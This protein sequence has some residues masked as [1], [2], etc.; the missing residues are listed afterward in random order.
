[1]RRGVVKEL[2]EEPSRRTE[3]MGKEVNQLAFLLAPRWR[4]GEKNVRQSCDSIHE[5]SGPHR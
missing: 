1:M 5:A 2:F 4:D 3:R